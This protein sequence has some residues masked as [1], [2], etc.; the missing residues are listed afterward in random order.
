MGKINLGVTMAV[1]GFLLT[2]CLCPL[3]LNSVSIIATSSGRP[4]DLFSPYGVFFSTRMGN[5]TASTYVIGLQLLCASL[6]ALIIFVVGIMSFVRM[7]S[8]KPGESK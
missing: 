2:C 1:L 3:A 7:R 4:S 5:V 8:I 6:I